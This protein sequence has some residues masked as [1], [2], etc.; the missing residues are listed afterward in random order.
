[1]SRFPA[2]K[3]GGQVTRAAKARSQTDHLA[4]AL[5]DE[6]DHGQKDATTVADHTGKRLAEHP[7]I[8]RNQYANGHVAADRTRDQADDENRVPPERLMSHRMIAGGQ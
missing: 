5:F 8:R 2:Y 6:A 3:G 1:M 4:L 7:E